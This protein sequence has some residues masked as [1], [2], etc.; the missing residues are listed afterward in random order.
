MGLKYYNKTIKKSEHRLTH[1]RKNRSGGSTNNILTIIIIYSVFRYVNIKHEYRSN[2][3]IAAV[4]IRTNP[5][6]L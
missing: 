2:V 3:G 1:L 5:V 4:W 6:V